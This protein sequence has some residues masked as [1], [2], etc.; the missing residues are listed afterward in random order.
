[1][2]GQ[3]YNAE[4]DEACETPRFGTHVQKHSYIYDAR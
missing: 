3:I 4:F 2:H 1:M